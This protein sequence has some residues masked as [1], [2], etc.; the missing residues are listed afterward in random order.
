MT[1]H[2]DMTGNVHQF[3]LTEDWSNRRRAQL[4]DRN[5]QAAGQNV[6]AWSSSGTSGSGTTAGQKY[7]FRVTNLY[8]RARIALMIPGRASAS[9]VEWSVGFAPMCM[10]MISPG[11][12]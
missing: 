9:S 4:R 1:G 11:C 8:L 5:L 2:G 12:R 10:R 3:M 6:R 7:S